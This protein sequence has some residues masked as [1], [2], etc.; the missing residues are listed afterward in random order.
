MFK[1]VLP[2]AL[3]AAA[4]AAAVASAAPAPAPAAFVDPVGDNGAA[5]DLSGV[6]VSNDAAGGFTFDV[7]FA[8]EY[9]ADGQFYL[10]LDT[11]E[12]TGTGDADELGADYL[13]YDDHA[14][15]AADLYRWNGSDWGDTPEDTMNFVVGDD[16][17]SLEVTV[18]KSELGGAGG[19]DFFVVSSDADGSDGHYDDGPSGAGSWEYTEYNALVLTAGPVKSVLNKKQRLWA[20]ASSVV[21]S[22]T[23]ATVGQEGT[24]TC[25][26]KA[27][28][29]KLRTVTRA[30]Y[31]AGTGKGSAAV[32]AFRLPKKH[33]KVTGTITVAYGGK[34]VSKVVHVRS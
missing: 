25:S 9:A 23:G 6:T 10:Y 3:A 17:R 30:F 11:D 12:N 22:D 1:R 16:V 5:P 7:T 15:H 20:I 27:G 24:I 19:F 2:L 31:S 13:I 26:A 18:N 32:C 8:S 33:V 29:S 14:Q 34:S 21:R 4:V 28:P